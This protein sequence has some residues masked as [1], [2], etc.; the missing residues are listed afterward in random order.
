MGA[1][2]PNL[3][4]LAQRRTE[5]QDPTQRRAGLGGPTE[6]SAAPHRPGRSGT[7]HHARSP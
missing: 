5:C 6:A 4:M 7:T 2:A 3:V 1:L